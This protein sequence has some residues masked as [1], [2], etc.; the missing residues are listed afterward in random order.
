MSSLFL[1]SGFGEPKLD[2]FL[3]YTCPSPPPKKNNK[4]KI[5]YNFRHVN[6]DISGPLP[7]KKIMTEACPWLNFLRRY[8]GC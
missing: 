5:K 1:F 3:H 8:L 2:Y 4:I 6:R 7:E